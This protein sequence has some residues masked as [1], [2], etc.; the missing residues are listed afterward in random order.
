MIENRCAWCGDFFFSPAPSEDCGG[1]RLD[2][3]KADDYLR[4]HLHAE[5]PAPT[6]AQ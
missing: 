3:E 6:V 5:M 1:C 4:W 2:T